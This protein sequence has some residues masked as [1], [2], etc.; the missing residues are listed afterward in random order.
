MTKKSP[1]KVLSTSALATFFAVS[2]L[3]PVATVSAETAYDLDQVIVEK[4]GQTYSFTLSVYRAALLKEFLTTHDVGYI[5]STNG[6]YYEI[7]AYR[8]ALLKGGNKEQA[9][10]LLDDTNLSKDISPIEG[11]FDNSGEIV[12][13]SGE[14]L[15]EVLSISAVTKEAIHVSGNDATPSG[16][17]AENFNVTVDGAKVVVSEVTPEG[18]GS[19][20]L[21]VNLDGKKGELSVNGVTQDFNFVTTLEVFVDNKKAASIKGGSS[22]TVADVLNIDLLLELLPNFN[23]GVDFDPA[24]LEEVKTAIKKE[25]LDATGKTIREVTLADVAGKEFTIALSGSD[26]NNPDNQI[27]KT[28]VI[29]FEDVSAK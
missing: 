13:P 14:E 1:Y 15:F 9:L 2:A 12:P 25:F 28:F 11:Q 7:S 17:S 21:A 27:E 8:S 6:K 23:T 22:T 19:Y 16:A 26:V 24:F 4:D 10:D 20:I 3:V 29:K 18:D 5:H